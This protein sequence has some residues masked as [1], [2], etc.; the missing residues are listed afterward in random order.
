[1]NIQLAK[2]LVLVLVASGVVIFLASAVAMAAD[3]II[4]TDATSDWRIV[5]HA[6]SL[7]SE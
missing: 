1:V 6:F 5:S 2:R 3:A 7:M 4:G